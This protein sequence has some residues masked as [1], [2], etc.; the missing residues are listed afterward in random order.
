[1]DQETAYLKA[2]ANAATYSLGKGTLELRDASGAL[3]VD[4]VKAQ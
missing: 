1:M 3:Q 2:L 4:Y